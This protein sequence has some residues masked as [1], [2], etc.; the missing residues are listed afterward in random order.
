M[1][2]RENKPAPARRR[3][4]DELTPL[5]GARL[6]DGEVPKRVVVVPW[7]E[8]E[9][10]AGSFVVD[11]EAGRAVVEAFAAHGTDLPIDFEH[12]TLGGSYASREGKAPAAGWVTAIEAVAGEGIVAT[13]NW[14]DEAR[15]ML[16]GRQYR[17][18]SPVAIV[19][20][21]DRKVVALHS[22]AL[23]NK[24]AIVG[25]AAI[26]NKEAAD[27]ESEGSAY[28]IALSQMLGVEQTDDVD[29]VLIAAR[30]RIEC[31]ETAARRRDAEA[32]IDEAEA[33]GKLAPSQ[34]AWALA[35]AIEQPELYREWERTAPV[36]VI[37][38]R[39]IDTSAPQAG[40]ASNHAIATA[41][42]SEF[43]ACKALQ[44]ITTEEAYV[45]NALRHRLS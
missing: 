31:L 7:G 38:G 16:T 2:D 40:S 20:K 1:A 11:E 36:V 41:A 25:M 15:E 43:A 24:P 34:R 9:S 8:V 32:L 26:V 33:A 21:R 5:I 6:A 45:A 28:L 35:L 30:E 14:T 27:A 39:L 22:V 29:A 37:P 44:S 17:Y 13:V 10:T 18:L 3:E 12:Q 23:T 19:R 4:E 42:R